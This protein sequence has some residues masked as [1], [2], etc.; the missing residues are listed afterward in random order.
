MRGDAECHLD[1][2]YIYG[3][4][5]QEHALKDEDILADL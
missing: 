2:G 1:Y 3:V 5:K 4:K